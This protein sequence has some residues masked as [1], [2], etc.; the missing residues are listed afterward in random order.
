MISDGV[1]DRS[2]QL[3]V[4]VGRV[5]LLARDARFAGLARLLLVRHGLD[6]RTTDDAREALELV[7]RRRGQVL[8]IDAAESFAAVA[9]IVAA[10]EAMPTPVGVVVVADARPPA[11]A[12]HLA[13]LPKWQALERLVAE[14]EHAYLIALARQE[15]A[16]A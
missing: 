16:T 3:P 10:V 7:R 11:V 15:P 6:V 5:V 2:S 14:L 4:S 13:V 8:V 1:P 12:R 9:R